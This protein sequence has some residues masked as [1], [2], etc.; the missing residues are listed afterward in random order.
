MERLVL[1]EILNLYVCISDRTINSVIN[2]FKTMKKP[3]KLTYAKAKKQAWD[4]FSR[5]IRQRDN[6]TCFTCNRTYR[7]EVM[8]AGHWIPG[9]HMSVLFDDRNCHAQCYHCNIGLKSNP[10]VYYDRMLEVY[11]RDICDE[12]IILDKQPRKYKIFELVEIKEKYD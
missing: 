10:I 3:K 9:R 11:G 8:Q 6:N 12:L 7:F 1:S 5:Y 2:S 4:A